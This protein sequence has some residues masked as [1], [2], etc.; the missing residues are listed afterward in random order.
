M[1]DIILDTINLGIL[2]INDELQFL[3]ANKYMFEYF[4]LQSFKN[5]NANT[6]DR[7]IF[8][9]YIHPEDREIELER[10]HKFILDKESSSSICRLKVNQTDT[11]K[12]IK[13]YRLCHIIDTNTYYIYT[14]EDIDELKK[15]EIMIKKEKSK[16][17]EEYNHKSLFLANMSHEIR[18][19]LNG[20]I[21]MLT[22]L[23][24]TIL[25]NEQRDY[26]N[27]LRECSI[28]LM[29]IINDILDFSKLDAGK[30]QLDIKCNNLR[31]CIESANDIL[32]CK[33]Y[34]KNLD[35][36]FIINSNVPDVID[37]DANRLKQVI[38]NLLNNSIKFTEKGSIFME[39]S[40]DTSVKNIV[41]KFSIS[42]TGCGISSEN[43]IKLF[44][45]FSQIT[46]NTTQKINE[47]TGLGLVISQKIINLMGGDIWLDW[48]ELGKGSRFCFT[49]ETNI[50][51]KEEPVYNITIPN[52]NILQYKKIFIL[53]DNRE[54]RLGL[55][56]LVHKWGMIPYTFSSA[57]EALYIL[58]LKQTNFDLGLVDVCM[59][60]M[61]GKQ[62]AIQLKEQ[63][64]IQHIPLIALSSFGEIQQDYLPY[65]KGQLIKPVKESRLK[66]LCTN[67]LFKNSE[68]TNNTYIQENI[69]FEIDRD[70]K[71]T[72]VILLVEDILI[73]QRIVT[74]FLNKLGFNNID[75]A[76]DGKKCLEMM[77]Q[78]HYDIILL[79]IKMP[80][81]NG[82]TVCKYILN[83][84]N[85]TLEDI[86]FKLNN[87]QKPYIIAV[88]AYSQGE[89][90]EKYINMGFNDYVSKPI[91]I[92]HIE[93]SMKT[94]IKSILS[95]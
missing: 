92:I 10:C 81:M 55:A 74:R 44:D 47:G 46:S 53:D 95:N 89:D 66:E 20:I 83:Y 75:I 11:Y 70:L 17:D 63:Y 33:I 34:E 52:N 18:T 8:L 15:L 30:V 58:K 31:K 41:L 78:K 69:C 93:Q 54:N 39:V 13:I 21:G 56:N 94:F 61:T 87:I 35:F 27:M 88:T 12:W 49:I 43:R 23:N 67:I 4:K 38:L 60:E 7:E 40:L 48:S 24:D 65:F 36:N 5:N 2:V 1:K 59:P 57:M 3:Y 14:I 26:I 90:K 22:L 37:I 91:N 32:A 77:S 25:S 80:N 50:C 86:P 71:E 45:S 51:E 62:F 68:Q 6:F 73:N 16:N 82:E 9:A 72:V 84:Y 64:E 29:T 19:P 42:D 28:N 76:S 79:D 85:N